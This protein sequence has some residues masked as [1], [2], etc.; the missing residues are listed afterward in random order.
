MLLQE[1]M[2]PS[3]QKHEIRYKVTDFGLLKSDLVTDSHSSSVNFI[4]QGDGT[5]M[6]WQVNFDT[7]HRQR[8]WQAVTQFAISTAADTVVRAVATPRLFTRTLTLTNTNVNKAKDAFV[9]FV[10]N[11]GGGLPIPPLI[12]LSDQRRM[13][14]PT[15]LIETMTRVG[16]DEIEYIVENPGL[17]TFPVYTYRGR[18]HFQQLTSDTVKL[19]WQTEARPFPGCVRIVETF[20]QAVITTLTRNLAVHLAEPN[21][22]VRVS[23]PRGKGTSFASVPKETWLG[24]V[25]EA[26]LRDS[27]STWEQTLSMFQPWTWGRARDDPND[28]AVT[29]W[30]NGY[31]Q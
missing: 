16:H 22:V 25:L 10:W 26:H 27:R 19:L 9:N 6:V 7:R 20:A 31:L 8:F 2:L 13:I 24:G 14:L 5:T 23:P 28:H 3:H 1:K 30:S 12:R 15:C 18:V 4:P 11:Q 17:F 21:A 29:E